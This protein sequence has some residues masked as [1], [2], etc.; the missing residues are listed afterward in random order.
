MPA[1]KGTTR[2]DSWTIVNPGILTL[3][4]LGGVDTIFLGASRLSD[5]QTYLGP[6]ANC[7]CIPS[8]EPARR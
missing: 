8:L 1:F 4:G 2:D 5:Y 6:Q 7:G 3:D